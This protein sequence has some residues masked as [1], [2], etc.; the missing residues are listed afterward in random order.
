[1]KNSPH[2]ILHIITKLELGG[3]QQN[4]LYTA[5][6]TDK[7]KFYSLIASG[8]GG[9]LSAS[10]A[11]LEIIY[12]PY[13]RREINPI[14]DALAFYHLCRAIKSQK[15][16]IVHTHS[17][18][19]GILGRL[20]ARLCKAPIIIHT[21]HGFG[22]N[23]RQSFIKKRIFVFLERI[24]ARITDI[25]IFVSKSNMETA[26]ALKIGNVTQYKLI[27]S[28]IALDKYPAQINIADK[29]EQL[30]LP[31]GGKI[32]VS[33]GNL[34]PQKNPCDFIKLAKRIS[35]E[36][37][38]TYFVFVGGG[39]KLKKIKQDIAG[40]NF[41]EYCRFIGWREDVAEILK[42]A[43]IF[44]LTSL[45]E[46]LPRSLVEALKS[47]L[48]CL[49]YDTDGV[50]DILK[51]EK[52][53]YLIRQGDTEDMYNK[54][55]SLLQNDELLTKLSEGARDTDLKEFAIDTMVKQLENLYSQEISK[56][57]TKL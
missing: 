51:S 49:C 26:K 52:N 32:I 50:S 14:K 19:A 39:E 45:W 17:S 15:P 57:R 47:G 16:D 13:L 11:D 9:I 40:E 5:A 34:K 6:N 31:A 25:L 23:K 56:K 28:G 35:S 21:F 8:K 2:K 3:A 7:K 36:R 55:K 12:I 27:R 18:K 10:G 53:G 22:F 4:T 44:I 37:H 33:V 20:A 30:K 46:G 1:M 24:C 42:I 38:D 41:S 54:L 43:D 29:K 48:P